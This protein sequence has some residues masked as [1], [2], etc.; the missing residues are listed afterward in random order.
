MKLL[1]SF[2]YSSIRT[3]KII[4]VP[5]Y[6]KNMDND[7]RGYGEN[8]K[9]VLKDGEFHEIGISW[10]SLNKVLESKNPKKIKCTFN[11]NQFNKE[12][13]G[14]RVNF[15]NC[16]FNLEDIYELKFVDDQTGLSFY[17]YDFRILDYIQPH[18]N[19]NCKAYWCFNQYKDEFKWNYSV[20]CTI[21]ELGEKEY[22]KDLDWRM[23]GCLY[24]KEQYMKELSGY[25]KINFNIL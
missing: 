20:N 23:D 1:N 18:I 3:G 5:Y 15:K 8:L 19:P 22:I 4:A 13:S 10:D 24:R 14:C 2:E 6:K 11:P 12:K 25:T 16:F 17:T 9:M 7:I 21:E